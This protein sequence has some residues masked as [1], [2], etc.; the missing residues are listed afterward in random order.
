MRVQWRKRGVIVLG[1]VVAALIVAGLGMAGGARVW[2]AQ[3]SDRPT[4]DAS[5]SALVAEV[6]A[7]REAV[8]RS[9]LVAAQAQLLLGRVQLQENRLVTLARQAQDARERLATAEREQSAAESELK[10]MTSAI[11][12]G[13]MPAEEREHVVSGAI[14]AMKEQLRLAQLQTNRLRNQEA[15]SASALAEEQAR[16]VDFNGRLEALE[17]TLAAMAVTRIR[18]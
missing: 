17:R 11:E 12:S 5:M 2:A 1:L 18:P 15:A 4:V 8:E 13:R 6:K 9:G 10:R 16:W 14:P 3:P 7:L